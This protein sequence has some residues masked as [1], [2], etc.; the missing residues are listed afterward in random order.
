MTLRQVLVSS[1]ILALSIYAQ[2]TPTAPTKDAQAISILQQSVNA[3]ASTIPSDSVASGTI[4]IVAGSLTT[5]G[6][7]QVLTRGS[8]QSLVQLTTPAGTQSVIYS[9]GQANELEASAVNV[10]PMELVV[11]SQASDFPLSLFCALLNDP[12]NSF[13]YVALETSSGQSL[14]HIQTWDSYASQPALQT[15]T[16]FSTRDIWINAVTG[17][18]QR[19]SYAQRPAHGG[20]PSVAVDVFYLNYQQFSGVL[21]P[22]TIQ[23]SMNGTPW[24]TIAVQNVSFNNGLTDSNFPVQ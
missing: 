23:K 5:Q 10:L 18:P 20:V 16:S 15:L 3:M 19:V 8:T 4:Q 13:R 14:N 1:S 7:I 21:Y 6:T 9:N 22:V 24:A 17:L 11:T 2:Q 12:D